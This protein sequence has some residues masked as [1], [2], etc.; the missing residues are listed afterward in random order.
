MCLEH[1]VVAEPG[2]GAVRGDAAD[3]EP[4]REHALRLD[5][6]LQVG[7]LAGD[8]E[9]ADEAAVDEMVAAAL[10]LL[11]GLLVGDDPE[12]DPDRVLL[13]HRG[14]GQQHRRQRPLHVVGAAAVEPVALDPRL[15]LV[16]VAGDDVEVAV[17]DDG[18][19][20]RRARPRPAAPAA[21]G[22]RPGAPRSRA[23]RASP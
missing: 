9:V 21:R 5:A 11:L 20:V 3:L 23:P 18:R 8:R 14:E 22:P 10:G 19:R 13:A 6:D 2:R 16:R 7:R 12:P 1:R 4:Q 15:E 17:Q